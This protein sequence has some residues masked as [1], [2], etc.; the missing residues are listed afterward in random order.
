M[1]SEE[2]ITMNRKEYDALVE[3]NSQLE[4]MLAARDANDGV[5]VPH[6]VALAIMR[7][8]GPI[9]AFRNQ[10][11]I[12]LRELSEKTGI[13]VGYLS[14]IERGR[15]PGSTSALARIASA[16]GATIDILVLGS[17]G[18]GEARSR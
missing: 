4:D 10:Q 13:A 1:T 9:L 8:K 2:T 18:P 3:R 15:K 6:E 12:T 16:L 14:E 11:G 7:G 5:L 17:P